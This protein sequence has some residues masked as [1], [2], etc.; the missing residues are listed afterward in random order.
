MN[1]GK[2]IVGI[3]VALG[4]AAGLAGYWWNYGVSRR[5][6]EFWGQE[7]ARLVRLAP[8]VEYLELQLIEDDL[9]ITPESIRPLLATYSYAIRK[10]ADLSQ[11]RG[12]IH[13]RN[14]ILSDDQYRWDIFEDQLLQEKVQALRFTDEAGKVVTIYFSI[15][16][17][18]AFLDT[19][20]QNENIVL[21]PLAKSLEQFLARELPR[22]EKDA[23]VNRDAEQLVPAKSE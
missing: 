19:N 2:I 17:A 21:G 16:P 6:M 5:A 23:A 11:A 14:A 15:P 13:L 22:T 3:A 18:V 12:L 20:K 4:I 8:K 9:T 7:N 1:Q 10:T